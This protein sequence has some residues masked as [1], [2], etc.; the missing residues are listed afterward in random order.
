M[1]SG[2]QS[3]G[4][5]LQVGLDLA[6]F[7]QQLTS[8]SAAAAGTTL[9]FD[10]QF[11]RLSIQNELNAL[12]RNISQRTYR[13][14]V[15]TNL[16][17]EIKNAGT[18]AKA[19]RGLDNAVQK[20]KGIANRAVGG[21]ANATIDAS[22]IQTLI[23]RA[24]KPALQALYS[25]MSKANIPM[26]D[27]G[28]GAVKDL[29]R[30]ILSG[31]PGITQ[32]I[33]KG[34]A[35]GLNPELKENGTKGAK[36]FIDAFKTAAGIASPSKVFKAL[37]EF[38][39]DGLEIGFLDGLKDFKT[40]A[41]SEIKSIVKALQLEA[42]VGMI[43]AGGLLSPIA[44]PKTV[45]TKTIPGMASPRDIVSS[46][47]TGRSYNR[48]LNSLSLLTGDP[49]L[50]RGRMA[51]L[52]ANRLPSTLLGSAATQ[53]N[54]E[55]IA[56]SFK[57]ARL[58]GTKTGVANIIDE[59]FF[60]RGTLP[61]A[62]SALNGLSNTIERLGSSARAA[63]PAGILQSASGNPRLRAFGGIPSS[64][65]MGIF[66][67]TAQPTAYPPSGGFLEFSRR[68][69]AISSGLPGNVFG[70]RQPPGGPPGG[71]G[72]FPSDGM[73]GRSSAAGG[74]STPLNLDYYKR[75]FKYAEAMKVAT[76]STKD[77][78]AASIPLVGGI[79][80][81]TGEFGNAIKQVLLFGTAYKGL[82]FITSLPG[83]VL[84]AAK[85]QQ[86]FTN[87]LQV[88]T[89]ET[90]SFAKE[91]LYVDNVQ[92][93]F[94]L[95]LET[96][97][98]GFT[99]LFASMAPTGFD[100]GSIE[101]LFTGISAATAALQLTPDKAERV[102]YAFGQMAS[103]GQI[104][105][106]EL[107]GQ[108]GDVL[109][110]ALAIF[111]KAAGMSV[112]EFSKAMEDGEFVGKRFREVFAQVSDELIDRFGSG[113]RAAGQ[114][115][116][117]LINTVGGDFKR[118]L[119]SFA[120]LANSAAQ[121]I[122]GPLGTALGTL[123]NAAKIAFGE[124]ERLKGQIGKQKEIVLDLKVG[125][126]SAKDIK[127]AETEVMALQASLDGLNEAMKDPATANQVKQIE[128][129][130]E[131]LTKAGNFV[132]NMADII[133]NALSPVLILVG[134][135]FT[136]VA[137][138]IASFVVGLT[139]ARLAAMAIMGAILAVK[140][141]L[142]TIG[143]LKA[144]YQMQSLTGAMAASGITTKLLATLFQMLGIQATAASVGVIGLR[145]ALIALLA[146]TGFGALIAILGSL[147]AAFLT[148]GNNA[149]KAAEDAKNSIQSIAEAR[150][151]GD[152]ATVEM[153]IS[154]AK[155]KSRD[156]E[157]AVKAARAV[158]TY[159]KTRNL[160]GGG[161]E[162][163]VMVDTSQISRDAR[164]KARQAKLEL[165]TGTMTQA[166]Y[167]RQ[168]NEN[169]APG[170]EG[171][172]KT[173]T[174]GEED[175]PSTKEKAARMGL[176]VPTPG[177]P[178]LEETEEERK[179]KENLA[180]YASLQDQLA[181]DFTQYQI[182]LL[183]I[184]HQHKVS[185]MNVFYDLQES[186][187]N[188]HQKAAIRFQKELYNI[189]AE[190][191]GAQLKAQAEIMKAQGSVAG[192]AGA[193][194]VTVGSSGY[195]D[196]SVLRTFL[197][198]QGFGRTTGDYTNKGHATPNH[199]LNAMDMGILGG[200]DADALRKTIAMERKLKATGAFGNQLFGPERDPY[201]HGAGKGGQNIH[202]HI[203]TPGGKVKMT[204]GLA[205]LMN[206]TGTTT[207]AS[208]GAP[209][210]V[211]AD[212]ARSAKAAQ[213]TQ[214][215]IQKEKVSVT[216]KEVE[217]I[218]KMEVAMENYVASIVPVAEQDL[219][220]RLLAQR[221]E[222]TTK[223]ASPA[224]LDAQIKYAE[225]EAMA[226]ENIRLNNEEIAKLSQTKEANGQTSALAAERI[227]GLRQA[228]EKLKS[229]LPISQIQLLTEAIDKQ[230]ESII[231]QSQA[232]QREAEDNRQINRLIIEGMT[233]QEAEA[234]VAA[235]R[236][237][238][239][240]AQALALTN[241]TIKKAS[242]ELE[243]LNLRKAQ[244]I[245]L[246][247]GE[248]A[249][250]E[251]LTKAIADAMAKKAEQEGLAPRVEGAATA[252]EQ[253]AVV[254]PGDILQEGLTAAKEKF[255]DLTDI[256]KQGVAAANAIGDAFGEAFKGIITGSM[257][258][259]EA[260]AGMFQSI[261]DH[262]ADMVAQMIAEYLKMQLI[263]GIKNILSILAPAAG[264]IGGG[265]SSGFNAGTSSAIDTG[266]AGWGAAFNTPLK[267][268]NGGIAPGG[269]TAF[270]N[271]GIV[272]GPTLGL[273]GEGRYNEAVIPLPDGKS[274]PVQLSGGDGGSQ[275]SSN[276]VVNV[277]NGQAQSNATGSNSSE[278]GRKI[279]GA[280]KQVIVGE[281]RP[282]G[283]LASR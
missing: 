3:A 119:E 166:E 223:I 257:T 242:A 117:G 193:E 277:S 266:A 237:R 194:G 56:P 66:S 74:P 154:M 267:L 143:F 187:A 246:T 272:T 113:A 45:A 98:T 110:G 77:F 7:R 171:A 109:P 106:E 283:L 251:R 153:E 212:Q 149:K 122:L 173:I 50:Y 220:N 103:K 12:G 37:G 68:A 188:S 70:G 254:K 239:D 231:R 230:V 160:P 147:G 35:S 136:S 256:E 244:G 22:K 82:A 24:T 165:P 164:M 97:R 148:M 55:E 236:L 205:S 156:I 17:T 151:R 62:S 130:V 51:N 199:T 167:F 233:R 280:V 278:L 61:K 259:R 170:R 33:A 43:A 40:K 273:V 179:R 13:L 260:L 127:A 210:K 95:N 207:A 202:L 201:G 181:K 102:I 131:E 224:I 200:S 84:N 169:A 6:F 115:L 30:S 252:L 276:I 175:L 139:V 4:I 120:P 42:R 185:L 78:R 41:V 28:E 262:F 240:Y 209:G 118:T 8:L 79:K 261:A 59:A 54:L 23:N 46:Q 189:V 112:K 159:T 63:A 83:Q 234:K 249:E 34:L 49:K 86:Q 263:E 81:L 282:G 132:K 53:M 69:T 183:D 141:V 161:R 214:L 227:N 238:G 235:D 94:G 27:I 186:R 125:G 168:L 217:A 65:S 281:L 26:E 245:A 211:T 89:Q 206:Y 248:T 215:A 72:R 213:Q 96:T 225:Q 67:P 91:L 108:L 178:G 48:I 222:L 182:D 269:F 36:V 58:G 162:K 39:A 253:G 258:A 219:Q 208:A 150:A 104:M 114:S 38:S 71:G 228:N 128:A 264:A 31:V 73:M 111:A 192:G 19:L 99:R 232:R 44:Q 107:K 14:E 204:P 88:A 25:E 144:A 180:Q 158:S 64:Q 157:E 184:E 92:R 52:G 275:I 196:K 191:Q 265:L 134:T 85:S 21:V 146:S 247:K 32:D 221:I 195:I 172:K 93:A 87:G 270:A 197:V 271:G 5:Q 176:N 9:S 16:A 241:E 15:A 123:S 18:L 124:T 2:G 243:I 177:T 203:P 126:A 60:G 105:S 229:S 133:G 10:V 268:A 274:V 137:G 29:R 190:Y 174:E 255:A 163:V 100:S 198:S 57:E 152:V 101:K 155:E 76:A 90:G 218:K 11:D 145:G 216:L 140:G 1:Q 226:T 75:A 20:N 138:T 142:L 250:Y 129:F 279:E 47:D 135:N 121:A 80:E 116:Q